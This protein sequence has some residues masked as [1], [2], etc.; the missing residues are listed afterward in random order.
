MTS[1]CL[2]AGRKA[3]IVAHTKAKG[4]TKLGRDSESKRLGVKIYGGSPIKCGQIIIRQRGTQYLPGDGV[5]R[6]GD[7]TLY[8]VRD[9]IVNFKKTQYINFTG[10]KKTKQIV[11]IIENTAKAKNKNENVKVDSIKKPIKP[12]EPFEADQALPKRE[13]IR[14]EEPPVI[15]AR[16]DTRKAKSPIKHSHKK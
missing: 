2:P 4:T 7:D 15:P 9:G 12:R 6:G 8:A 10:N 14:E 16:K 5:K 3:R 11:S 1:A 13:I